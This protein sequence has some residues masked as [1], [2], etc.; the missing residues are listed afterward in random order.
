MLKAAGIGDASGGGG[1]LGAFGDTP[2]SP[3]N[4]VWVRYCNVPLPEKAAI[5]PRDSQV[6]ERLF[7][8][9]KPDPFPENVLNDCFCRFGSLID[10]YFMPGLS[11]VI[12]GS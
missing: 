3:N 8:V 4:E 6:A 12:G 1:V 2:R 11:I 9:S 10:A 7:I 5:A